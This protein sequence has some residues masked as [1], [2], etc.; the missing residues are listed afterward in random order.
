MAS[1]RRRLVGRAPQDDAPGLEEVGVV[2]QIE[3]EGRVLLDQ[4]H[5][6]AVVAG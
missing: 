5:G 3:G 4:E 6:H 1:S 2:G